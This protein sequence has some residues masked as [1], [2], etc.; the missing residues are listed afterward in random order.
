MSK[1]NTLLGLTPVFKRIAYYYLSLGIGSYIPDGGKHPHYNK[2]IVRELYEFKSSA[3]NSDDMAGGVTVEFFKDNQRVR[4]V[5][6]RCQAVG[7]GGE[8]VIKEV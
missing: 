6:F 2:V 5:E 1:V 7:G 4:W 8:P 3:L